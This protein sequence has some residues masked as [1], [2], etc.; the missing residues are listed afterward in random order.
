MH[1]SEN[2]MLC[3]HLRL[4]NLSIILANFV[5]MNRRFYKHIFSRHLTIDLRMLVGR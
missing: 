5:Q 4:Q 1:A 3:G 2:Q